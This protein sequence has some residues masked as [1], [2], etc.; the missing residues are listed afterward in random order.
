MQ[1]SYPTKYDF[2]N[3]SWW[4]AD[5]DKPIRISTTELSSNNFLCISHTES[6]ISVDSIHHLALY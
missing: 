2:F 6:F 1:T 3:T 5:C 4:L